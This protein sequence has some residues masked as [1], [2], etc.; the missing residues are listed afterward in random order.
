MLYC[1]LRGDPAKR[2]RGVASGPD[3]ALRVPGVAAV[4][5][6]PFSAEAASLAADAGQAVAGHPGDRAAGAGRGPL[7]GRANGSGAGSDSGVAADAV[8]SGARGV[9]GSPTTSGIRGRGRVPRTMPSAKTAAMTTMI[10]ASGGP[11]PDFFSGVA[12][13]ATAPVLDL[14]SLISGPFDGG[15]SG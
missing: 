11:P 12:V 6:L 10:S 13:G 2:G 3:E 7:A 15:S 5:R 9:D 14:G 1:L 8:G 4:G